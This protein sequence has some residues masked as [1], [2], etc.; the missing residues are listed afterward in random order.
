LI[1][2]HAC[3]VI[4]K[5]LPASL[6]HSEFVFKVQIQLSLLKKVQGNSSEEA[7]WKKS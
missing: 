7:N 5:Q 2:S 3:I 1:F 6:T 4:E